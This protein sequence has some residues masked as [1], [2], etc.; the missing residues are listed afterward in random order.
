MKVSRLFN[1]VIYNVSQMKNTL[2]AFVF[3]H[4][5]YFALSVALKRLP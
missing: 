4:L 1:D 3:E 5:L 2:R